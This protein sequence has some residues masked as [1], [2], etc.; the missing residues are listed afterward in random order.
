MMGC[1]LE[2]RKNRE[3]VQPSTSLDLKTF[4]GI[5]APYNQAP[6]RTPPPDADNQFSDASS[7]QMSPSSSGVSSLG[8]SSF[9]QTLKQ[10]LIPFSSR[11]LLVLSFTHS[12]PTLPTAP[13]RGRP[14]RSPAPARTEWSGGPAVDQ[15]CH[16]IHHHRGD[17]V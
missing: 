10:T 1:I 8:E 13:H 16:R 7:G 5:S 12:D 15:P 9:T 14:R 4:A 2:C 11:N 3:K 6:C 17:G